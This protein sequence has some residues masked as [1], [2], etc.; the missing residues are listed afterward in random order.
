VQEVGKNVAM[1][2]SSAAYCLSLFW[3]FFL[4]SEFISHGTHKEVQRWLRRLH[5]SLGH[6]WFHSE[7]VWLAMGEGTRVYDA[8][9]ACGRVS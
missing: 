1:R 2:K 8:S 6:V 9:G 5:I 3:C 7:S 4:K